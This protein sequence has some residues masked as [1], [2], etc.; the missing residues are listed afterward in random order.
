MTFS[1]HSDDPKDKPSAIPHVFQVVRRDSR[2]TTCS[3]SS[4]VWWAHSDIKQ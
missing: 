3:Y 1:S 2:F 4:G